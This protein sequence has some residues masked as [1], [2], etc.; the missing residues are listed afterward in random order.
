MKKLIILLLSLI[1]IY[2]CVNIAYTI[3]NP[4]EGFTSILNHEEEEVIDNNT[5]TFGSSAFAR[6][7]NFENSS[8][9]SN[10][11]RLVDSGQNLTID[12]SEIDDSLSLP[13]TVNDLLTN[14][15]AI[16]SNQTLDQNGVTVYYLYEEGSGS[17]NANIYFNKNDKNY[18]ISGN[19]IS[20]DGSDYF[21]NNCKNIIN[22]MDLKK[23]ESSGFSKWW[24]NSFYKNYSFLFF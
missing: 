24:L 14:D 2:M 17:Y 5:I 13:D 23:E 3:Y 16:T 20:Y 7:E 22:S 4:D 11:V 9:G 21:I 12:V 8:I 18:L 1:L 15:P 10:A 19:N 6:L